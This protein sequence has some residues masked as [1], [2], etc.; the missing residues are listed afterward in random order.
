MQHL[1]NLYNDIFHNLQQLIYQPASRRTVVAGVGAGFTIVELL[2]VIVVIGILAA[3][4]IVAFNGIQT[5][6]ENTKTVQAVG[7]Y[8][9]ALRSYATLNGQYPALGASVYPCLGKHPGTSCGKRTTGTN[10]LGGGSTV[11][12]ADF[13]E[14]IKTVLA[15]P[16]E[17]SSQQMNCAGLMYSGGYY[18]PS[19][20]PNASIIYFL[21]GDQACSGIGGVQS[22][23]RQQLDD[24]T[25]C[26]ANLPAVS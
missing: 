21:R 1:M 23:S 10:C 9:K 14:A 26:R 13:D 22:F 7:Q 12:R 6:A 16:P 3:I 24:T 15:S 5:Q 11:S 20:G 25:Q 4:V 2:I 17:L 8:V 19:T 18:L